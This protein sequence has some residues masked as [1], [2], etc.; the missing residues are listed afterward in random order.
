MTA[1]RGHLC[2]QNAS[3]TSTN[4]KENEI[5]TECKKLNFILAALKAC[6]QNLSPIAGQEK[7]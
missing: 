2:A 4:D 3:V 5:I 6:R 7:R 1:K